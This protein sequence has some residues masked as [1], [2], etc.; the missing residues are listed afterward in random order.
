[1]LKQIAEFPHKQRGNHQ[2]ILTFFDLCRTRT[3]QV[4]YILSRLHSDPND[5]CDDVNCQKKEETRAG[6]VLPLLGFNALVLH[7]CIFFEYELVHHE[8]GIFESIQAGLLVVGIMLYLLRAWVPR[9]G[10]I[11][12]LASALLC[13]SFLLREVD[14]EALDVPRAV[15]LLGSGDG[16][17]ALLG[18]L[19]LGL[20]GWL[21]REHRERLRPAFWLDSVKIP[22]LAL[23]VSLFL[24]SFAMDRK[25][26]QHQHSQLFEELAEANAYFLIVWGGVAGLMAGAGANRRPL[27]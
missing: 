27:W 21:V 17:I 22:L 1:M 13:L 11:F 14:V 24:V 18:L 26:F 20:I 2:R 15:I 19:W 25:V 9:T 4:R 6:L 16:K 3:L 8:N 7:A 23:V 12:N 10:S 5:E